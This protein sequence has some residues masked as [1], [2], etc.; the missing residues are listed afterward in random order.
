MLRLGSGRCVLLV[1]SHQHLVS[2]LDSVYFTDVRIRGVNVGGYICSV[3]TARRTEQVFVESR[4][5]A[6]NEM[7]VGEEERGAGVHSGEG[8]GVVGK[9]RPAALAAEED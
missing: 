7:A 5:E 9:K 4:S 1:Q 3:V 8:S 6:L 2:C